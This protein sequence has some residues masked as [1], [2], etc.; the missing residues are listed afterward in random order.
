MK[1][2]SVKLFFNPLIPDTQKG[3]RSLNKPAVFSRTFVE[4]CMTFEWTP[5]IKG[6]KDFLYSE[7][8]H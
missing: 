1:T 8:Y 6:L 3:H 4:V 7:S 2:S 5:G